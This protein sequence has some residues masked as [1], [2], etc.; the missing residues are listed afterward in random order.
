MEWDQV[1]IPNAPLNSSTSLT[2]GL[3]ILLLRGNEN[4]GEK[5]TCV[6]VLPANTTSRSDCFIHLFIRPL[7]CGMDLSEDL[8]E[9]EA[10]LS[11]VKFKVNVIDSINKHQR[12]S[13]LILW[14][15]SVS[16]AWH[17]VAFENIIIYVTLPYYF[18]HP[19]YSEGITDQLQC[20]HVLSQ[21]VLEIAK[22]HKNSV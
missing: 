14:L 18:T 3:S 6:K 17:L 20:L 21:S 11:D 13:S 5:N 4:S 9:E 15:P 7:F 19:R 16:V 2:L 8:R 10:I 1:G 22:H 12:Q